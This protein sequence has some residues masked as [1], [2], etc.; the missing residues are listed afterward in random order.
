LRDPVVMRRY[1]FSDDVPD[2]AYARFAGRVRGES[3]HVGVKPGL[4]PRL[5]H[6][7]MLDPRREDAARPLRDRV[8]GMGA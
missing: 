7:L 1:L 3:P 8:P 5:A 4:V 2:A 6:A